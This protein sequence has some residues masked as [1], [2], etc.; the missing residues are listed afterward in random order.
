MPGSIP[1]SSEL[2]M[3]TPLPPSRSFSRPIVQE[4][5][6]NGKTAPR[7][8]EE[9]R[10][11]GRTLDKPPAVTQLAASDCKLLALASSPSSSLA[12]SQLRSKMVYG[13]GA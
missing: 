7:S 1:H 9:D 5:L 10:E 13:L 12:F 3:G 2:I 6:R 4:G 8:P 11:A